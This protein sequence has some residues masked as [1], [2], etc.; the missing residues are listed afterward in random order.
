MIS[1]RRLAT[2]RS[3]IMRYPMRE[4]VSVKVA[5]LKSTRTIPEGVSQRVLGDLS[6]NPVHDRT[7]QVLTDDLVLPA[8]G[9]SA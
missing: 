5:G 8:R 4:A 3:P 6:H 9:S 7:S 1:T 2:V